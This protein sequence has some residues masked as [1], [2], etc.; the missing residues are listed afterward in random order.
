MF[1]DRDEIT[2][3][4]YLK[5]EVMKAIQTYFRIIALFFSALIFFQGCT[6][7]KSANVTLEEASK[8]ENKVKI[9][10]KTNETFKFKRIGIENVNYY[11]VKK[12]KGEMTKISLD[13]NFIESIKE[14]DRT[15]STILTVAIP[16]AIIVG[17]LLIIG[18][19]NYHSDFTF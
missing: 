18:D 6:V 12:V 19:Q 8:S 5:N 14:K 17:A 3:I 16:V 2:F 9:R 13:S 10:T 1:T 11:G 7:Y 4:A 15:M